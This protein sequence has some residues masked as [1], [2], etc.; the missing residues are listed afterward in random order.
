MGR[1][2]DQRAVV[3]MTPELASFIVNTLHAWLLGNDE[4]A[5]GW[6]VTSSPGVLNQ[7][8]IHYRLASPSGITYHVAVER[9]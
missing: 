6:V 5:S 2:G 1:H 4:P 3:P 7:G 8:V 9:D